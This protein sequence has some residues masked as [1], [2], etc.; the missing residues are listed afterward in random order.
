[1]KISPHV[2]RMSN[3]P[4][5]RGGITSPKLLGRRGLPRWAAWLCNTLPQQQLRWA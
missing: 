4:A 1:M 2:P 5:G 3:R